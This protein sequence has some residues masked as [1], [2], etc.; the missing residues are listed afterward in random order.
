MTELP[1]HD[2]KR[3][4]VRRFRG[5][6]VVEDLRGD[7]QRGAMPNPRYVRLIASD[8]HTHPKV[9]HLASWFRKCGI[10][11]GFVSSWIIVSPTYQPNSVF[12][13]PSKKS[14][15]SWFTYLGYHATDTAGR[16][17]P[18]RLGEALWRC[19][20]QQYIVRS[21]IAKHFHNKNNFCIWNSED[22]F[23]FKWRVV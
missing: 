12:P 14:N 22:I 5:L 15:V 16:P 7:I 3:V 18:F 11:L 2:A 17:L 9:S 10:R 1:H 13:K 19:R 4:H 23:N 21:V 8:V 20:L 6:S